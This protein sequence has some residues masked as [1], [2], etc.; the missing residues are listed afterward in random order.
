[1]G[2]GS[3][4]VLPTTEADGRLSAPVDDSEATV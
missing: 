3:P 2:G 4:E 1:M